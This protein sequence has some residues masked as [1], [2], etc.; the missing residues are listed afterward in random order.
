ED[1]TVTP[2]LGAAI[3]DF[4]YKLD[5]P[6]A[7]R[8]DRSYVKVNAQ[9]ALDTEW[10]PNRGP[11][12]VELLLSG[13]PPISPPLPEIF[14]EELV[15]KYRVMQRNGNDLDLFAGVAFEQIYYEDHQRLANRVK[16]DFGPML[17]VGLN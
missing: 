4:R 7:L 13:T 17:V 2:S 15:G 6:G 14:V 12:A 10:R 5:G 3:L 8:A 16:A 1:W 11:F 9:L